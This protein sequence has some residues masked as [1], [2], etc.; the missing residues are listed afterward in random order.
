MTGV[1]IIL[2]IL[3]VV[4]LIFSYLYNRFDKKPFIIFSNIFV[5]LIFTFAILLVLGG[6]T[7]AG[8]GV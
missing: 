6:M 4:C 5:I 1:T 7:L 2:P 8:M 3:L